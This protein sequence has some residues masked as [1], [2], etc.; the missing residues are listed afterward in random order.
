M[1]AR[2][3]NAAVGRFLA[4]DPIGY[5]DQMNLYAY[6]ANDPV[7]ATDPTGEFLNLVGGV[8]IGVV[9]ESVVIKLEGGDPLD[10]EENKGRYATAAVL[11]AATSGVGSV[12][13][14][15]ARS[16]VKAAGKAAGKELGKRAAVATNV[17]S[18]SLGG[19]VGAA[20]GE[21]GTQLLEAGKIH[22]GGAIA[23]KA[24]FGAAIGALASGSNEIV[25]GAAGK[26]GSKSAGRLVAAAA[27][28]VDAGFELGE[29]LNEIQPETQDKMKAADE[30]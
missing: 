29:A 7:N 8:A 18:D 3:Y 1:Q 17:A 19:A 10:F 16:T 9:V 14:A 4:T 2:S 23:R 13:S 6:V 25:K 26:L 11:G 27:I 28:G 15:V 5:Q 24:G 30:G 21:A 12:T 20:T 22:D